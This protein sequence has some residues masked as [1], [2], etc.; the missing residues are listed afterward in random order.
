M[1]KNKPKKCLKVDF[2][3]Q[4]KCLGALFQ[5]KYPDEPLRKSRKMRAFEKIIILVGFPYF[6]QKQYFQELR[7]LTDPV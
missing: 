2:D 6:V 5:Q 1:K 4:K 3:G 7:F